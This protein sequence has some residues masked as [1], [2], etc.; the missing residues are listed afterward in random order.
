MKRVTLWVLVASLL[1]GVFATSAAAQS[2]FGWSRFVQSPFVGAWMH[3]NDIMQT[4]TISPKWR[5]EG[6]FYAHY[7]VDD[8]K[9]CECDGENGDKCPAVGYGQAVFS[10]ETLTVELRLYCLGW[11]PK[12]Q[13]P[14]ELAFTYDD[15]ADTLVEQGGD[16]WERYGRRW[17]W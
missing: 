12:P 13:V 1:L 5:A 3:E 17:G 4:L 6:E 14:M 16:V 2:G 10:K 9:A 7:Y 8:T 15:G 11:P